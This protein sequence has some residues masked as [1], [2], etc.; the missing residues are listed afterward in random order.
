M[1]CQLVGHKF[2]PSGQFLAHQTKENPINGAKIVKVARIVHFL[3]KLNV[4]GHLSELF[5]APIN[6][7]FDQRVAKPEGPRGEGICNCRIHR[8]VVA[9]VEPTRQKFQLKYL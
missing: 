1:I 9:G 5:V 6:A 3:V 8:V 4:E 7:S 2:I